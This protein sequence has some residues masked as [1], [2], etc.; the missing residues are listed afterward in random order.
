MTRFVRA[1][2]ALCLF[3]AGLSTPPAAAASFSLRLFN[4]VKGT[5]THFRL[6]DAHENVV[7]VQGFAPLPAGTSEKISF[8]LPGTECDAFVDARIDG[9]QRLSTR[10]SFCIMQ[11]GVA[12]VPAGHAV[13]YVP[14]TQYRAMGGNPQ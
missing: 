13:R 6:R 14:W 3:A 2:A 5:L 10:A 1:C 9:G 7:T 12:V 11:S 8:T 4:G